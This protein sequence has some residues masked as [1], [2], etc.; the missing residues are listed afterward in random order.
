L[1]ENVDANDSEEIIEDENNNENDVENN[2]E[3]TRICFDDFDDVDS[4]NE[5][6]F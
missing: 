1:F 6:L 4:K 3:E 2:R 5:I